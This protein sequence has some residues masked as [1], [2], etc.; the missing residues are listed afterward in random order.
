M[1]NELAKDGPKKPAP[2]RF[3]EGTTWPG[4]YYGPDGA[5]EIFNGPDEV[6]EG[7]EDHPAKVAAKAPRKPAAPPKG[8][9]KEKVDALTKDLEAM[10]RADLVELANEKSLQFAPDASKDDLIKIILKATTNGD[11]N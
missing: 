2:P 5:A 9:L 10:D 1:P 3:P 8:G 6:P 7:W 11:G 4:W